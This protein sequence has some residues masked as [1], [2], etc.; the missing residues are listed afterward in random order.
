MNGTEGVVYRILDTIEERSD[1]LLKN[2]FRAQVNFTYPQ[3]N[4]LPTPPHVDA[5]FDHQVLIYYVFDSDGDTIFY[6]KDLNVIKTCT[7]KAGRFVLFDG[8]ILHS[9]RPPDSYEKRVVVNINLEV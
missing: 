9:A 5:D 3:K 1:L 2:S 6:D 7:P 4:N 8:S